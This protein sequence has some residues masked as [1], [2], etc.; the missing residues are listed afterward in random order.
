MVVLIFLSYVFPK[1]ENVFQLTWSSSSIRL[2]SRQEGG[3]PIGHVELPP[4]AHGDPRLF[5]ELHREALESDFVSA[6]IHHWID[7]SKLSVLAQQIVVFLFQHLTVFLCSFWVQ[8][9]RPSRIGCRQRF[10][11]SFVR[12]H[13]ILRFVLKSDPIFHWELTWFHFNCNFLDAIA[14]ERER[15]SVLGAMC[16]WGKQSIIHRGHFKPTINWDWLI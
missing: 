11:R 2:G 6:N 3:A 5:V 12:R 15:S 13:C 14:D 10:S 7:L 9:T 8:A 16:N 4:W 1:K